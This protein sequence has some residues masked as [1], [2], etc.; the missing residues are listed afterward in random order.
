MR[1]DFSY[2]EDY[3]DAVVVASIFKMR[4]KSKHTLRDFRNNHV[5]WLQEEFHEDYYLDTL[6]KRDLQERWFGS[7]ILHWLT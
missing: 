6:N 1:V 7:M 4:R 3:W 2:Q 5:Y